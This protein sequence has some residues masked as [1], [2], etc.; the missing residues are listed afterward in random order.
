V[1]GTTHMIRKGQF[2]EKNPP[3][4]SCARNLKW[5]PHPT[6]AIA[7]NFASLFWQLCLNTL[8]GNTLFQPTDARR[9]DEAQEQWRPSINASGQLANSSISID[10]D[11]T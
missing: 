10:V 7:N 4:N 11:N 1:S 8:L 5:A 3:L 2:F 9:L 6:F